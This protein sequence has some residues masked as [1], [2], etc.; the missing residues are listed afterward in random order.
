MLYLG[1]ISNL[2]GVWLEC[3][4]LTTM[5]S[6]EA[7]DVEIVVLVAIPASFATGTSKDTTIPNDDTIEFHIEESLIC[8]GRISLEH[9]ITAKQKKKQPPQRFAPSSNSLGNSAANPNHILISGVYESFLQTEIQSVRG[10]N[11]GNHNNAVSK[12]QV[13]K[14]RLRIK[15]DD[16]QD[17]SR[18]HLQLCQ[19][20]SIADDCTAPS[21]SI[22]LNHS[23]PHPLRDQQQWQNNHKLEIKK[24]KTFLESDEVAKGDAN[25]D[26]I[27]TLVSSCCSLIRTSHTASNQVK[28]E[29]L[30]Q[31][32][33]LAFGK[34]DLTD[35]SVFDLLALQ[36]IQQN[37]EENLLCGFQFYFQE[38][39]SS[40]IV[41]QLLQISREM[42]MSTSRFNSYSIAQFLEEESQRVN[43]IQK[44]LVCLTWNHRLQY[45]MPQSSNTSEGVHQTQTQQQHP[46]DDRPSVGQLTAVYVGEICE[47]LFTV[48]CNYRRQLLL[49]ALHE[50]L[51]DKSDDLQERETID[52]L[53]WFHQTICLSLFIQRYFETFSKMMIQAYIDLQKIS[54]YV[55][56]HVLEK[57]IPFLNIGDCSSDCNE[58]NIH[59]EKLISLIQRWIFSI[60][61]ETMMIM[62]KVNAVTI[63]A[64]ELRSHNRSL[65]P[66]IEAMNDMIPFI[67]SLLE[68]IDLVQIVTLKYSKVFPKIIQEH[69][70]IIHSM[71]GFSSLLI[72]AYGKHF[73]FPLKS[74]FASFYD[75]DGGSEKDIGG[76]RIAGNVPVN[77][78]NDDHALVDICDKLTEVS[79]RADVDV[80]IPGNART[81]F[82]GATSSLGEPNP[83]LPGSKEYHPKQN[84]RKKF[85]SSTFED[86]MSVELGAGTNNNAVS[87][88][89]G[90]ATT[91][92]G[93]KDPTTGFGT[94]N[95]LVAN[96][97]NQE[98]DPYATP[99]P[100]PQ[101]FTFTPSG[102]PRPG[103]DNSKQQ[104][105]VM[106]LLSSNIANS[107]TTHNNGNNF[108]FMETKRSEDEEANA[109]G[110]TT[111]LFIKHSSLI[112]SLLYDLVVFMLRAQDCMESM[113]VKSNLIDVKAIVLLSKE[114]VY[115]MMENIANSK[116]WDPKTIKVR[117]ASALQ[118]GK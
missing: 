75:N 63:S 118:M 67:N 31:Y 102:S 40:D 90:R 69:W 95:I 73:V 38:W 2:Q 10:N 44:A 8:K 37:A 15:C 39:L 33:D 42:L 99:S 20:D 64:K 12:V 45:F 34:V 16:L 27:F 55:I 62:R 17:L 65:H 88:S 77:E 6:C 101:K 61:Y 110:L 58:D 49:H 114:L 57:I 21:G 32:I 79:R 98:E 103:V 4:E 81:Y 3:N 56:K 48:V 115:C 41:Q 60:V 113:A 51:D 28:L 100:Y 71:E 9:H 26:K 107:N 7:I 66:S 92:G 109:I 68:V 117:T 91:G 82:A 74:K 25:L 108:P 46:E 18:E 29:S 94:I 93:G 72:R 86:A 78:D 52:L 89:R 97:A 105:E 24:F 35:D 87:K 19:L 1:S 106:R 80:D 96:N 85:F 116:D 13:G 70:N 54:F 104:S 50:L 76:I 22:S 43:S 83:L 30:I 112:L 14:I 53:V 11:S 84:P 36:S 23:R 111:L 5:T 59:G 47:D